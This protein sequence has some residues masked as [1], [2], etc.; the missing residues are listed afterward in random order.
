MIDA[1]HLGSPWKLGDV[2]IGT[3][4]RVGVFGRDISFLWARA[5][6]DGQK[7]TTDPPG[8]S[9]L[10]DRAVIRKARVE[11]TRSHVPTNIFF[12]VGILDGVVRWLCM[13][14]VFRV[15]NNA[16]TQVHQKTDSVPQNTFSENSSHQQI[17]R[18]ALYRT[19]VRIMPGVLFWSS[20]PVSGYALSVFGTPSKEHLVTSFKV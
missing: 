1:Q 5:T 8:P 17:D 12:L 18:R 4:R 14:A 3:R 10:L 15:L 7:T 11:S 9:E 2:C 20:Q 16:G 6:H 13:Q 19:F